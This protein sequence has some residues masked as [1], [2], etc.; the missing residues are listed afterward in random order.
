MKPVPSPFVSVVVPAYNEEVRLGPTLPQIFTYFQSIDVPIEV[1]VVDDGSRD[2]TSAL[3]E[4]LRADEPRLKLVRFPANRGKGAA[5]REGTLA[6]TGRLV[7]ITDAD[8]S[9]PLFEFDHLLKRMRETSS[10]VVI[11]SRALAASRV[12]IGQPFY[13]RWMGKTFNLLM[14]TITR[15]PFHDTQCGFKLVD[16]EKTAPI[17]RKMVIEG[18]A[19]DVELLWL[20]RLAGLRILEE[21]IEWRNS[22]DTRVSAIRSSW[23][24]LSDVLKLR[25]RVRRGFY[26][27]REREMLASRP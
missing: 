3:V 10:D 25:G 22:T 18:F 19:F 4:R 6:A 12:E 20:A 14:R 17:F 21:P 9:T 13:R 2:G 5:V 11:G 16:R 7:L 23:S 15:L 8:L 1:L 24:M 26:R 27:E